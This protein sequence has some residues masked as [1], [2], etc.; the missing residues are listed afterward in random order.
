MGIFNSRKNILYIR[1]YDGMLVGWFK[2]LVIK[3]RALP[4]P[5]PIAR[6]KLLLFN[7]GDNG[8]PKKK[9]EESP[10]FTLT[11]NVHIMDFPSS[12]MLHIDRFWVGFICNV[13]DVLFT[14]KKDTYPLDISDDKGGIGFVQYQHDFNDVVENDISNKTPRRFTNS[15]M[16]QIG[17]VLDQ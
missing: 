11:T 6:G 8:Q 7:S 4:T 16:F 12:R 15:P 9:L 17:P 10:A 3:V 2:G 13:D 1:P 14:R 5:P